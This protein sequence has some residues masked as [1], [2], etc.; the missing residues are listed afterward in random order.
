M[1]LSNDALVAALL[2]KINTALAADAATAKTDSYSATSL[3]DF[4][5]KI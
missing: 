5:L 1:D 4:T 2:P 3:D